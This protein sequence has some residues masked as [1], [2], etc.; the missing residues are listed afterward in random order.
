[1]VD[2]CS[3]F[4]CVGRSV[5]GH[6]CDPLAEE[7][8]DARRC[9]ITPSLSAPSTRRATGAAKGL[10]DQPTAALERAVQAPGAGARPRVWP[11]LLFGAFVAGLLGFTPVAARGRASPAMLQR[12]LF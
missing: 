1:M 7:G 12:F 2:A 9:T 4:H 5:P 6:F 8:H 10:S 11:A 3:R